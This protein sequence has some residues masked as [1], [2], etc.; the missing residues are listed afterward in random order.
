MPTVIDL[1]PAGGAA[2]TRGARPAP[3]AAPAALMI[4]R[5]VCGPS[6]P[7]MFPPFLVCCCPARLPDDEF[8]RGMPCS[9]MAGCVGDHLEQGTARHA[10]QALEL[11]IDGRERRSSG[12]RHHV[13][14]IV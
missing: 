4:V 13:P 8:A 5:R 1:P 12:S 10:A 3:S 2:W 9:V 6:R 7:D 11:G 14:V